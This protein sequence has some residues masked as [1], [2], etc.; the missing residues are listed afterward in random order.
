MKRHWEKFSA[1]VDALTL[2]ERVI[3]FLMAALAL[4]TAMN[5]L[6]LDPKDAEQ[7]RIA[8][9]MQ[10]QQAQIAQ[11]RADIARKVAESTAD[12]DADARQRLQ[13]L[14]QQKA[15]LQESLAGMQRGLVSP[16]RIAPLLE[17]ILS[18]NTRLRLVSLKKLP[19]VNLARTH[20]EE[21]VDAG[22]RETGLYRHGVELTVEGGYLDMLNYLTELESLST[23]LFWGDLAFTV[24]NH[25]NASMTVTVYTLSLD[26][27]WLHI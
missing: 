8:R 25:P 16:D 19:V 11:L 12:P 4:V 6:A 5:M 18:R 2:R 22:L 7:K 27:R 26:K 13:L 14:Q 10:D 24:E 20:G 17:N 23:Q 9:H 21:M 15:G 1:R 3:I